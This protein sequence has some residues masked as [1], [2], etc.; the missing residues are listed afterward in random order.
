MKKEYTKPTAK[1]MKFECSDV[2]CAS[3]LCIRINSHDTRKEYDRAYNE[4]TIGESEW[5]P[6]WE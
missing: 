2:I 4:G 6:G 1:V 5:R 3:N